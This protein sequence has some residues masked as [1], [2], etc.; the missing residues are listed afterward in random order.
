[1]GYW[2]CPLSPSNSFT[3]PYPYIDTYTHRNTRANTYIQAH[4]HIHS[5]THTHAHTLSDQT[6]TQTHTKT[7]IVI[8]IGLTLARLSD[9]F[10][11]LWFSGQGDATSPIELAGAIRMFC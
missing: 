3:P 7:N 11:F 6:N 5:L 9:M 8:P 2:R 4:A 10:Y 1:M